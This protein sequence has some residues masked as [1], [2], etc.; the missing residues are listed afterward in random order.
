MHQ[1]SVKLPGMAMVTARRIYKAESPVSDTSAFMTLRSRREY[2]KPLAPSIN[3][4][5]AI[6]WRLFAVGRTKALK[7]KA[8]GR[9]RGLPDWRA[10]PVYRG[11]D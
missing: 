6:E 10:L 9:F 7:I 4:M 11:L 2:I 8:F 5:R 3:A 1:S